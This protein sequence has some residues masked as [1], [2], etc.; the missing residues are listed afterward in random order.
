M[1][2][3]EQTEEFYEPATTPLSEKTVTIAPGSGKA[4]GLG[5]YQATSPSPDIY[6]TFQPDL[7]DDMGVSH[8][9]LD[10]P[11]ESKYLLLYQFHNFSHTPCRVT[12]QLRS[13]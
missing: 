2:K 1:S 8:E 7:Q 12:M 3:V 11:G 4:V 5:I 6:V 13:A 9:R 10:I